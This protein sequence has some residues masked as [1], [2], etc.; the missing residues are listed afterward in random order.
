MTINFSPEVHLVATK[1]VPIVSTTQMMFRCLIGNSQAKP[2]TRAPQETTQMRVTQRHAQSTRVTLWRSA[3]VGTSPLTSRWSRPR[4]ITNTR[5]SFSSIA[6][7]SRCWQTPRIT[8]KTH[9]DDD[10]QVPLRCNA[11]IKALGSLKLSR[12]CNWSKERWVRGYLKQAQ[13][14]WINERCKS[15]P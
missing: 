12:E 11:M 7:P 10:D 15:E 4:T 8:R 13:R 6:K 2:T 5:R 1:L 3:E 14:V 9:G